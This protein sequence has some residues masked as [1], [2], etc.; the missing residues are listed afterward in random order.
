G[1]LPYVNCRY[2][3]YDYTTKVPLAYLLSDSDRRYANG[4]F[5]VHPTPYITVNGL[6]QTSEDLL[7][8]VTSPPQTS[9]DLLH[10]VTVLPNPNKR[11]AFR[12]QR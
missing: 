1:F 11:C 4:T 6:P 9:G 5:V 7:Y 2:V 12:R 3:M 10:Y 8:Y